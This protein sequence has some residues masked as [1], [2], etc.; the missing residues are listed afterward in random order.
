M[1]NV[2]IKEEARKL[3]FN[4]VMEKVK[5]RQALGRTMRR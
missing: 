4:E 5:R 3:A 1:E 2:N